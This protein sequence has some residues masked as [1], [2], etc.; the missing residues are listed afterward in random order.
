MTSKDG[1]DEGMAAIRKLYFEKTDGCMVI[2]RTNI[3]VLEQ[4]KDYKIPF[5]KITDRN[6]SAIGYVYLK[7][8]ME[9]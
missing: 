3:I 2:D 6:R 7:D 9:K 1:Q 5:A 8:I 4:Y